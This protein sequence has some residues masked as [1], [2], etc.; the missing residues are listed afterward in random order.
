MGIERNRLPITVH[1]FAKVGLI[2]STPFSQKGKKIINKT[3]H[4]PM[5]TV[6]L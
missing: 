4:T 1:S 2:H 5:Q 3:F 6:V